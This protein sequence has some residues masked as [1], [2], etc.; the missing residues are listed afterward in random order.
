MIRGDFF[1]DLNYVVW[2]KWRYTLFFFFF[3]EPS[4]GCYYYLLIAERKKRMF[5]FFLYFSIVLSSVLLHLLSV[6]MRLFKDSLTDWIIFRW[7][8]TFRK[9]GIFWFVYSCLSMNSYFQF[10]VKIPV[11]FRM[12]SKNQCS[13]KKCCI[14]KIIICSD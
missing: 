12:E 5:F 3:L 6:T 7:S 11:Y 10:S 9:R 8:V 13:S 4:L 1:L 14:S 2:C